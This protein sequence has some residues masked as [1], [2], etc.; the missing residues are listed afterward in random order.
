[1]LRDAVVEYQRTLKLNPNYPLAYY[2]LGLTYQKMHDRT[3][4]TAAFQHFLQ[5]SQSA[6]QDSPAVLEARRSLHGPLQ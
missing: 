6:D 2:H 4:A 1:M 3:N 5:A